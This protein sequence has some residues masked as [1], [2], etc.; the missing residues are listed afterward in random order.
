METEEQTE[1]AKEKQR[2]GGILETKEEEVHGH[3]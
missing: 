1:K 2:R 3:V